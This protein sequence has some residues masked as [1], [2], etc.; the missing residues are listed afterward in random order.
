MARTRRAQV[1]MEPREYER[2]EQIARRKGVPVA[3]LIRG[4]V[5]ERY[6]LTREE[7]H[8][9]VERILGLELPTRDWGETEDEIAG[10]HG[11]GLS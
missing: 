3:E 1:L 11:H 4:A 5:R 2:L 6:L 10:A 9:L 7:R 8:R